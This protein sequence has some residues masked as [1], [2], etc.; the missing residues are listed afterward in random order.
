[1]PQENQDKIDPR[2][3]VRLDDLFKITVLD[4]V[5]DENGDGD[6]RIGIELTDP[7]AASDL[8]D[9]I[10]GLDVVTEEPESA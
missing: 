9:A 3:N 5:P 2:L 8:Y 6:V 4:E 7:Q 10:Q 1:M